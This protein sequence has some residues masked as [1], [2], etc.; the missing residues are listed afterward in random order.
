MRC[1]SAGLLL[2]LV[3]V[4]V[5]PQGLRAQSSLVVRVGGA[6]MGPPW[7][8]LTPGYGG[9]IG[10][11]RGSITVTAEVLRHVLFRRL[12]ADSATQYHDF[13]TLQLDKEF[14]NMGTSEIGYMLH[15]GGGLELRRPYKAAPVLLGGFGA[16]Y[17]SWAKLAFVGV[18]EVQVA[19]PRL[20][21]VPCGT[22]VYCGGPTFPVG[23]SAQVTATALVM[24][25]WRP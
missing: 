10:V 19:F 16:R 9:G 14:A 1:S 8:D 22:R 13:V 11:R 5:A 24:A 18:L 7:T 3:A 23:G 25:E 4:P 6:M 12:V 2:S 20:E 17:S 15:V 21:N